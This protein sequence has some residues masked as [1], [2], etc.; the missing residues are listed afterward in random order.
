VN[1]L[2]KL[3]TRS[4]IVSAFELK[5]Y[6][7]SAHLTLYSL[8]QNLQ[9]LTFLLTLKLLLNPP[10]IAFFVHIFHASYAF[11]RGNKRV[12]LGILIILETY[13]TLFAKD[14]L[15]LQSSTDVHRRFD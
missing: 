13:P 9:L 3:F 10:A 5:M 6:A 11:A 2:H 4:A 12:L 15:Q 8:L 7:L 14:F 1:F